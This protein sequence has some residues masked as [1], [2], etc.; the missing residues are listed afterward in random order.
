MDRG[1]LV[2]I[3]LVAHLGEPPFVV[4]PP[5]VESI[6]VRWGVE[7]VEIVVEALVVEPVS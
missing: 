1:L 2:C 5:M 4:Q 3:P 6:V 7:T